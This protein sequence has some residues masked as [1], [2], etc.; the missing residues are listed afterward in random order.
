MGV[1]LQAYVPR[2]I[3]AHILDDYDAGH[4]DAMVLVDCGLTLLE[5]TYGTVLWQLD[6]EEEGKCLSSER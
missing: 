4:F 5:C 6:E 3:M 1:L 2:H